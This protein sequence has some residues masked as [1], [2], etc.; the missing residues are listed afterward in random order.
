MTV[1]TATYVRFQDSCQ[2][3]FSCSAAALGSSRVYGSLPTL[4]F[5]DD[6]GRV[7]SDDGEVMNGH[8]CTTYFR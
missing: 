8:W 5:H 7:L 3:C 1:S 6:Y 2:A 4:V